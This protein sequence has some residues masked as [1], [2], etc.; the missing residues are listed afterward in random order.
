MNKAQ[1]RHKL[2]TFVITAAMA[3]GVAIAAITTHVSPALARAGQTT[4]CEN[5]HAYPPRSISITTSVTSTTV[6]AGATFPVNIT[7]AGGSSS[8]EINW[9]TTFTSVTRNNTLFN[10]SPRI[11]Y[12][13][14]NKSGSTSSTLTAPATA[15]TYIVRVYAATATNPWETAYRD[16]TVTV[17]AAAPIDT[18]GPITDAVSVTPNPTAGAVSISLTASVGDTTTG[19]SNVAAAEYFIDSVGANGA[20]TAMAGTFTGPTVIVSST[21][22]VSSLTAGTHTIYV[23]GRDAASN[24]GPASSATLSVSSATAPPT[25]GAVGP[26][27]SNVTVTPNPTAGAASV[28]LSASLSTAAT[29]GLSCAGGVYYIDIVGPN[30]SGT[31]IAGTYSGTSGTVNAA[32]NISSLAI[33]THVVYIQ[34][35]D[36]AGNWGPLMSSAFAVS[37]G[38]ATPDSAGPATSAVAVTPS[39]TNGFASVALSASVSDTTA[40]GSNIAAAEYFVDTA[41]ANGTGVAMSGIFTN[42]AVMAISPV[43]VSALGAGNHTIY[44]HGRDAAGNWGATASVSL[45]VSMVASP[46]PPPSSGPVTSSVA[47]SPN[48]TNGAPSVTLT[49]T[50]SDATTGNSII[51]SAEYF[52]DAVGANGSG[53]AMTGTFTSPTVTVLGTVNAS[54]LSIGTHTMYVHGKDVAGNW[55]A[56]SPAVLSVST[57]PTPPTSPTSLTAAA[58]SATQ[59]NL[60]WVD[61]AANETGMRLERSTS[62]S[63]SGLTTFTL[64]AGTTAYSDAS[65]AASTTYYYRIY[66]TNSV[67]SSAASNTATVTTSGSNSLVSYSS[68]IQPMLDQNCIRCHDSQ[69]PRLTTYTQ[70]YSARNSLPGMGASYLTNAQ[71]QTLATWIS[72]GALN[73]TAATPAAPSGLVATAASSAQVNLLWTNNANNATGITLQR[74]I[75]NT[76]GSGLTAF[77]LAS[78]ATTYAD[79]AVAASTTYYYRVYAS[80]SSGNSGMSNTATVTTPASTTTPTPSPSPTPTPTPTPTP[81]SGPVTSNVAAS[82]NPTNGAS[83]VTLT[84][85]VSDAST[86]GSD[87][88]RAEYFIDTI[89]A[90]GSGQTMTAS[91]GTYDEVTETVRATVSMSGLSE[92]NHT[93]YVRG[94][95]SAGNWGSV[96][97]VVVDINDD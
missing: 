9:P 21:V 76:F 44:V 15:G 86:G 75:N 36:A 26:L 59:V 40:G 43:S 5:C 95:D 84:A 41:G 46:P 65:V 82:P 32:V 20:G 38:T 61:N 57:P 52:V 19:N 97:S 31:P 56:T 37:V 89:G 80:N 24:W 79:T 68:T 2:V 39:P 14:P 83:S 51:S 62:S 90:A 85:S 64:V 69:S 3:V 73:D 63:F 16:I 96:A 17:T 87:I 93:L 45:S 58:A 54:G 60:S 94:R 72:Q 47:A 23:H 6:A 48:P 7:W 8:T 55:G 81:G 77:S 1:N 25:G 35:K 91:D 92:G 22:G 10:P 33:G 67:G 88:S 53:S 12:S 11:P 30:G 13:G 66:A 78:T 50:V 71:E 70:V 42:P 27:A 28:I 74:A 4:Q 18:A 49:A 34:G 29:S